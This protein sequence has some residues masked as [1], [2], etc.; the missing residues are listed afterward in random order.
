MQSFKRAIH[1]VFSVVTPFVEIAAE[2]RFGKCSEKLPARFTGLCTWRVLGID[3]QGDFIEE[4][5][6]KCPELAV[7]GGPASI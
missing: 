4:R 1:E 5:F 6:Q 7:R 2:K 3:E